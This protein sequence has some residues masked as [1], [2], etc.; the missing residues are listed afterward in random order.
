MGQ[1]KPDPIYADTLISGATLITLDAERRVVTDGAIAI[2]GDRIAAVGKRADITAMYDAREIVDGHRFVATPGFVN[3]HVHLTETLI[4][5]FMPEDLP[6]DESLS[7]WVIPL[8]EGQ[9]AKEQAIGAQLAIL[10]MVRTGTT[11]FLEAGTLIAFDEVCAAIAETGIRGRVGRWV[12]DRA[13]A[14]GDDQTALTDAA[15]RAL[16]DELR[17][18]PADGR[19]IAAWPIL[20]GH[21]T[22]TDA[23]WQGA[24]ALADT[25][26]AGI[27][28]HMSPVRDDAEWYIANTGRRPIEHLAEIGVLGT[29]V[30]LVHMVHVDDA[31]IAWLAQTGTNVTHCPGAALKGGYGASQAGRFPEMAAAGVNLLLGT[32][33]ADQHDLM[34]VTTLMAGL[35]KDARQDC[36]IFPAH[37]AIEL[38]TINGARAMGMA[39]EI[40]SLEPGKK[41]DIVLHDTDRPEWRPLNNAVN[42]LV[43]SADGRGV[44]SVWVDGRRVVDAYRCTMI[45]EERLYAQA[46]EAASAVIARSGLPTISAWPIS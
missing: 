44:H 20:I 26:G 31:E 21:N 35:F 34:R 33:G 16:E 12:L 38:A 25:N 7:Q 32:D 2:V 1:M 8:Y 11:C 39:H 17:R 9:S 3:G 5:G 27:S 37:N 10:G 36:G 6:F 28:A 22:N 4:R 14:P 43:W 42:Q 24:K 46:Q 29:N 19:R 41:A 18:Y 40:G 45:D 23:V 30:N 15:L 13:F